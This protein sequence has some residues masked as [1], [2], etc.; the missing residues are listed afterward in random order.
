VRDSII[1]LGKGFIGNK[2][3]S[4]L[5]NENLDVYHISRKECDYFNL[6]KL[7]EYINTTVK[8]NYVTIINCSGY[9][10][11][12]NVES[13]EDN[14]EICFE[15]NVKLQS[16]LNYFC[17]QHN[18][19]LITI[20]SGCIYT[21]YLKE[22]SETDTPN[23]GL[24]DTESSFYSKTKHAA[25]LITNFVNTSI[26]RIRI[27]FTSEINRKNYFIKILNYDTLIDMPNSCTCVEDLCVFIYK[28]ISL[29]Y[30][31]IR[32][33]I[34]NVANKG[35]IKASTVVDILKRNS[36]QNL[37][38]QFKD[39]SELNFKVNRSNCLLSTDKIS[40]IGLELPD[41]YDSSE[42]CIT[43]LKEQLF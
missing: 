23:F 26:L 39:Y 6:E 27:P 43:A 4:F 7:E 29:N 34:Y 17:I 11:N 42:K 1:I 3:F 31:Y 21:G 40:K 35:G 5:H 2:L 13:C 15:Y 8:N 14:K 32:P 22:Y 38:W 37:K 20:S 18:F 10:G 33:G 41:I 36:M 19:A 12:P 25:E 9:T 24:F 16:L 30:Q 28:F